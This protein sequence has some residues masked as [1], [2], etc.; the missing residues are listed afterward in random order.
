MAQGW[1]GESACPPAVTFCR[2]GTRLS[3]DAQQDGGPT[4]VY[5]MITQG[6]LKIISGRQRVS[7]AWC[8]GRAERSQGSST[9]KVGLGLDMIVGYQQRGPENRQD[10]GNSGQSGRAGPGVLREGHHGEH[11]EKRRES[12]IQQ[13]G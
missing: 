5:R 10:G 7:G 9:H 13:L 6:D 4:S 1:V 11:F 8:G 3:D 12:R 2:L